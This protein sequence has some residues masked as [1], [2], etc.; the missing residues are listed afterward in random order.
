VTQTPAVLTP[1]VSS[2]LKLPPGAAPAS[3]FGQ[4]DG[5]DMLLFGY[6]GSGKTTLLQGAQDSESGRNL[7]VLDVEKGS[8]SINDRDDII[9]WRPPSSHFDDVMRTWEWLKK[10]PNHGFKT[11]GL[12]T[13]TALHT[14]ALKKVMAAGI[15]GAMP[16]QPE[17][18]KANQLLLDLVQDMCDMSKTRGWNVIFTAHAEDMVV[19]GTGTMFIRLSMTPGVTKGLYAIVST[20]GY[21]GLQVQG[22]REKRTLLLRNTNRVI[23][24]TRQPMTGPQLPTEIENPSLAQILD[25][26]HQIKSFPQKG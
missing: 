13:L 20:V 21:L 24:K 15:P 25:H 26:V 16:S 6:G 11:I 4:S 3:H 1:A 8:R 9:V 14:L 2:T 23:A 5:L 7:F 17:Y 22:Q 18:G 19:E 10:E 12:E